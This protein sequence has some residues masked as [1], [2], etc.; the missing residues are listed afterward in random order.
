MVESSRQRA[1]ELLARWREA[2]RRA[3]RAEPG[4]PDRAEAVSACEEARAAYQVLVTELDA[5]A[6]ELAAAP[7]L[8]AD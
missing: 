7:A 1:E 6:H 2:E 3:D 8:R 5:S 4:S